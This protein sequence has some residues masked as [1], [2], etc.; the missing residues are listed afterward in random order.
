[1]TVG[2][3]GRRGLVLLAATSLLGVAPL[4]G[5]VRTAHADGPV[6]GWGR[7]HHR[8]HSAPHR[9][10]L[11]RHKPPKAAATM[12]RVTVSTN[13]PG[14]PILPG[15]TYSWP[16]AVTNRSPVKAAQVVF[17]A[18]LPKSLAFVSAE[19]NCAW[20]GTAAVCGLGALGPGQTR[21]GV[22]TAQV[23]ANVA[24]GETISSPAVVR[25]DTAQTTTHFPAVRV[26]ST[27]DLSVVKSGPAVVR[28]GKPASYDITV[29][30][31]GPA[32][33]QS[34]VL[35]DSTE[36]P[37]RNG[38][39]VTPLDTGGTKCTTAQRDTGATLVCDVGAL[40]VGQARSM[41]VQVVPGPKVRP[42]SVIQAPSEVGSPT[43]DTN[44]ANNHAIAKTKVLPGVPVSR[45]AM[46]H[47]RTLIHQG[48]FRPG[49][50][51]FAHAP[52]YGGWRG[53]GG[54]PYT[55]APVTAMLHGVA[56]LVGTGLILYR[57]GRP[58]R[59]R[60]LA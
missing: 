21:T 44:L 50:G 52:S 9:P 43:F 56:A 59:R 15:K 8:H 4:V 31:N 28:P 7:L 47:G 3:V 17:S 55:G 46:S 40:Q 34:V 32:A 45:P 16:Y 36:S 11:R 33:A 13:A 49:Q 60:R 51:Q 58:R 18:P 5:Q 2:T 22:I 42:G 41:V 26:A 23:A 6:W 27:A 39:T 29:R 14:V 10:H 54:L 24:P 12:A 37:S 25:W 20:Q 48:E 35:H 19:Q 1:M 53:R 30:N 38:V 57:L